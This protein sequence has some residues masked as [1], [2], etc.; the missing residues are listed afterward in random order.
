MQT[1]LL[2]IL[3][4]TRLMAHERQ[5]HGDSSV[6]S[7]GQRGMTFA[8]ITSKEHVFQSMPFNAVQKFSASLI[9][10]SGKHLIVFLEH[11]MFC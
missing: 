4:M 2:K 7:A 11:P 8:D 1:C 5:N 9:K 3:M 6:R 10:E